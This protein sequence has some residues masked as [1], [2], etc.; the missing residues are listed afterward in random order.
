MP[1]KY[2]D[3]E[4]EGRLRELALKGNLSA[5]EMGK[6]LGVSRNSIIAKMQRLGIPSKYFDTKANMRKKIIKK[7]KEVKQ[8]KPDTKYI[9]HDSFNCP[10]S[11]SKKMIDLSLNECK[12]AVY[13]NLPIEYLFCA[14]YTEG[15]YCEYHTGLSKS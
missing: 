9:N 4:R 15:S 2:W 5:A 1:G 11:T 7:K 10:T 13:G 12:W 8:T 3:T 14:D 6:D